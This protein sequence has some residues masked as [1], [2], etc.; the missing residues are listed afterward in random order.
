MEENKTLDNKR[1]YNAI[2][3]KSLFNIQTIYRVVIL[4]WY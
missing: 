3:D 1:D 4:N 2:E